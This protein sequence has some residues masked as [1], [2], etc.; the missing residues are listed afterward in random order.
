MSIYG[1]FRTGLQFW[2]VRIRRDVGTCFSSEHLIC[3]QARCELPSASLE[4]LIVLTVARVCAC[5]QLHA[6]GTYTQCTRSAHKRSTRARDTGA[7]S[8]R[9]RPL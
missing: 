1:M 3:N 9:G 5:T 8:A 7:P 2:V 4:Q 6:H